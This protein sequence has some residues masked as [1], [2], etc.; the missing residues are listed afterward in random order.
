[1]LETLI[2]TGG[3]GGGGQGGSSEDLVAYLVQDILQKLPDDFDIE[4]AG[5]KYPVQYEQSFNQVLCQV[6]LGSRVRR[7]HQCRVFLPLF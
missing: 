1:M 6:G 7:A 3:G 2:L 5:M 4:K